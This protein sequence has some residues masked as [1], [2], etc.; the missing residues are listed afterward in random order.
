MQK[1]KKNLFGNKNKTPIAKIG[2][3]VLCVDDRAYDVNFKR[4][5]NKPQSGH[6]KKYNIAAQ[7]SLDEYMSCGLGVCLGCV[8]HTEKG[9]VCVCKSGPVFDTAD[10]I[11]KDI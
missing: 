8:V 5:L 11:W 4:S 2:D 10:I 7:V 6:L 3:T 9:Q 1:I